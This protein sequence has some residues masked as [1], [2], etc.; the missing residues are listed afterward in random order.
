ML[1]PA[2]PK[3]QARGSVARFLQDLVNFNRRVLLIVAK[4]VINSPQA[5]KV[6]NVSKGVQRRAI[7]IVSKL[8]VERADWIVSMPNPTLYLLST[9]FAGHHRLHVV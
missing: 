9:H 3:R 4:L 6:S 5:G 7:P 8:A 1:V 2:D